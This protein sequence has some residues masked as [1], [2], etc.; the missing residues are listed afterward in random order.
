MIAI[1]MGDSSGVGPEIVLHS[2]Q[3]G[4]LPGEFIVVGDMAVLETCNRMLKYEVPLH[5]ITEVDAAQAGKVNV[6][7]LGILQADEVQ[8]GQI[9]KKSGYAALRY[10][11]AAT[12]LALDEKVTAIVTLPVNKEASRLSEPDFTGHTE[13]VAKLCGKK[14]ST[15]MLASPK[16][17]VTHVT[18]HVPLRNAI[19]LIR[20]PRV[21]DT[22]RITSQVLPRL[23]NSARIAVAGLNPHAGENGSFGREEIDEI[24]PAIQQAQQEGIDVRG[25]FPPD[26]VFMD[27]LKGRYDAIICMYHDQGHIPMK[28]LDFEGATNITLGLPIVRTSVDHGTAFDIAYKGVAFTSS[29]RDA[30]QMALKLA[31]K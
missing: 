6:Y 2:F 16:A 1:T 10:V 22:I 17:I 15:L 30:A 25:P 13:F 21:L 14:R 19:D 9:S 20:S 4:E 26:T 11:E 28:I 27:L 24:T 29:L 3:K 31:A 5:R 12:R 18:T 8:P 23:R 7:D